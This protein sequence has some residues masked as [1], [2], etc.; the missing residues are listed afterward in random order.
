MSFVTT[1][2]L[3]DPSQYIAA[4]TQVRHLLGAED[5]A[6]FGGRLGFPITNTLLMAAPLDAAPEDAPTMEDDGRDDPGVEELR[7]MLSLEAM[8]V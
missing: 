3:L 6:A 2:C 4:V 1:R 8:V 5:L 7:S